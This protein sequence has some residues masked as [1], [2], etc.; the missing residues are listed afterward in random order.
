MALEAAKITNFQA[1]AISAFR[2]SPD[3]KTLGVLRAHVESDVVLLRDT[4]A[5]SR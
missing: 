2:F 3:G 4:D 5:P 1:D